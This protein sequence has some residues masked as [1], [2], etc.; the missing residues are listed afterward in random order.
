MEAIIADSAWI[1]DRMRSGEDFRQHLVPVLRSG[2]LYNSGI[3]RAEV[4]RGI[5]QERMRD[6]VC[7][8]FDIVPEVPCDA[9]LWQHVSEIG[10]T[11]GRSG[12]WPPVTDIAIAA[13]ALRVGATIISPD[14]HFHDIS[15]LNVRDNL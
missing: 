15:G 2:Q 10:W 14:A 12:K 1:I 3:I 7:D 13:C 11:L 6:A 8:F 4:L 5:K 9:R